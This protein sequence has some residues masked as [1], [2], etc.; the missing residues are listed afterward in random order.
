[1]QRITRYPLHIKNI[2]ES[3]QE[4]HAD[5]RPLREALERAEELCSQVNEGVRE[6]ENSDRLEWIQSHVQCEGVTENLVFNSLTNCLGPRKLLHSGKVYKIK[7]NKELWAFLFNDF[8][9]LT[10]AAKQFSSSGP[11]KLFSTKNNTQLKM[12]KPPVFLN[13]VLVKLPDPSSEEPFFHISHIDRVYSL[14]TENINERTAWVQKIKAASEDF[15]ETDKKKR[16]KAY[17]ARSLK[18]SGIGRLL[19]TILEATELKSCKSNGE[20]YKHSYIQWQE[21]G[22]EPFGNTWI[23]T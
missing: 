15:L 6:K 21:K 23:S 4:D 18:A 10:H 3:T 5:R 7:S 20:F 17:Q 13:E 9:L 1:M 8:L 2:L 22:C 16:E 19:V 12:Y 14:K 11:D